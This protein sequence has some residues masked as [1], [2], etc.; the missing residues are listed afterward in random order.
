MFIS[1]DFKLLG[2][3]ASFGSTATNAVSDKFGKIGNSVS[4]DGPGRLEDRL[5]VGSPRLNFFVKRDERFSRCSKGSVA[6]KIA[7]QSAKDVA[8]ACGV[9]RYV[10]CALTLDRLTRHSAASKTLPQVLVA[11]VSV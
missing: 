9:D 2:Q 3:P 7:A 1:V 8:P 5:K 6:A 11:R 4:N 10:A